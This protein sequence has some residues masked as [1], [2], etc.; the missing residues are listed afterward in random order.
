[1]QVGFL[2]K[3]YRLVYL[4]ITLKFNKYFNLINHYIFVSDKSDNMPKFLVVVNFSK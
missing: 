3:T 1:M 4:R 2:K